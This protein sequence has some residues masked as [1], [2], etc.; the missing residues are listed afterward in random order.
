MTLVPSRKQFNATAQIFCTG[1]LLNL[2]L[3]FSEG[4]WVLRLLYRDNLSIM[5]YYRFPG[6][7]LHNLHVPRQKSVHFL[8][9]LN[10][11]TAGTTSN[12]RIA[13]IPMKRT[14]VHADAESVAK[15]NLG[16]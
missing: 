7:L 1:G 14:P 11:F 3:N 13:F 2:V 12:G 8:K 5:S 9:F 4:S 6:S 16:I 15:K 10:S